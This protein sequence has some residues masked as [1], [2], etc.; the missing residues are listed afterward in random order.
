MLNP[1]VKMALQGDL[2]AFEDEL[3]SA[4]R[5]GQR[6]G[7]DAIGR[8]AMPI[9]RRQTQ[10]LK[11]Y[12]Y[13]WGYTLY[14]RGRNTLADNPALVIHPLSH[15]AEKIFLAHASG[16][17]IKTQN[18]RN[19]WI[20]IPDSPADIPGKRGVDPVRSIID[21][22]GFANLDIIPATPS[23]PAM[24][25]ARNAS[26]TARGRLGKAGRARTQSGSYRKGTADVPLFF[27]VPSANLTASV[28]IR[29]GFDQIE[30]AAPDLMADAIGRELRASGFD[31]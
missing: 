4:V 13:S 9:L 18:A 24:A 25:V 12:S 30:R 16:V 3:I 2:Q 17:H 7:V 31:T 22:V 15:K 28:D 11:G 29:A 5:H 1:D 21:R 19:L 20:P 23:R 6:D 10:A 26:I 8:H 14:P 27:L